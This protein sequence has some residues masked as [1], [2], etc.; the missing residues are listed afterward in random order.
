MKALKD[1]GEGLYI[2]YKMMTSMT[3]E[4]PSILAEIEGVLQGFQDLFEE[5][6]GLPPSRRQ[7]HAIPLREGASIPNLW[8]YRYPHYQKT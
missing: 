2:E 6:R 4:E 8:P 3:R 1:E 7:D 5:P